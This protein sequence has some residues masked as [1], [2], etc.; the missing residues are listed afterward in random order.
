MVVC[1]YLLF[2]ILAIIVCLFWLCGE[3]IRVTY[4]MICV[5]IIHIS[6]FIACDY[7]GYSSIFSFLIFLIIIGYAVSEFRIPLSQ[8]LV[9]ITIMVL[10][11]SGIQTI[12]AIVFETLTQSTIEAE[13]NN[14]CT[15]FLLFL[16]VYHLYRKVDMQ[17]IIAYVKSDSRT[18]TIL[19]TG[20]F[21]VAGAYILYA[22]KSTTINGID[23]LLFFG[24]AIVIIF[25]IGTWEKYRMQMREKQIEVE[26]HEIYAES[27]KNLID[28]IRARQHEFDNHL[29]AIINQHFTCSTYEELT[30]TQNE[31]IHAITFDN[32]YNKLLRQGNFVYIGF[33]YGK[34]VSMEERGISVDYKISIGQ[35]DCDMPVYK[36]IEITSDLLNNACEALTLPT[37]ISHPVYMQINE[38]NNIIFLEI[39]NI[40]E[41]LSPDFVGEC[42]KKGYSKKG[43]G[44]GL[45]LYNVKN[46][47]NQYGAD[48]QFQ[49]IMTNHHNWVSFSVTIP[50]PIHI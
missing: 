22:K 44:R 27:Y 3:K 9:K 21:C 48:I 5:V 19:L 29:Q 41:P 32:R 20:I 4:R 35:L 40:G 8:A 1:L 12:I 23:Y 47:T 14:L 15:N 43:T 6:L 13:W 10:F 26:V 16:L 25:L 30:H 17:G 31:Y 50:K 34:L 45:G 46:I 49:N 39:R 37:K 33:L 11:C 7:I 24:M 38:T 18:V 36:I 28:E 2:E 42:F